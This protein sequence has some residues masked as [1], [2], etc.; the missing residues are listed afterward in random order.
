[1]GV[2]KQ[3][4]GGVDAADKMYES[5][6]SIAKASTYSQEAFLVAG[7]TLVGMGTSADKTA[8]YLQAITFAV[9]G[10]GG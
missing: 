4:L 10:F 7:K 2:F 8:K 1:M 6:L 5:L 3:M 9:D